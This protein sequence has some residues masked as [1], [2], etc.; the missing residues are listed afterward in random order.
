MGRNRLDRVD[1][2]VVA[3][4]AA[5]FGL[6]ADQLRFVGGFQN[7]IYEFDRN[8]Q[9]YVLRL[10]HP[11][12]RSLAMVRSELNW[13][14]Y[15]AEREVPVSRPIPSERGLLADTAGEFTAVAC[16]KA[17]GRQP[18]HVEGLESLGRIIG[19]MHALACP[20][21]KTPTG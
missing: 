12:R 2:V 14:L 21:G 19:Q 20:K 13:I 16:V 9:S 1:D 17:A 6:Q 10:T 3:E 8:G 5:R 15:L 4:A 18:G 7:I 11:S